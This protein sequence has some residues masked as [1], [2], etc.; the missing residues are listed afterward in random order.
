MVAAASVVASYCLLAAPFVAR[1]RLPWVAAAVL[2]L[3]LCAA[4][5]RAWQL[6][7]GGEAVAELLGARLLDGERATPPERRLLNVVHEMSIA[8]S[9]P[10]PPVYILEERAVNALVAGV[11]P[12]HAVIVVTRG[13]VETLSRDELQAVMGHEYS[14]IVNGDMALNLRMVALLAGLSWLGDRGEELVWR[15]ARGLRDSRSDRTPLGFSA[16]AGAIVAF[17]GFPGVVAADAIRAAVARQR[18]LLADQASVQFTRNAEGV[19]GALDTILA[20][21]AGTSVRAAHAAE[22]SHLFFASAVAHW[23]SFATHPPIEQR[24]YRADPRFDRDG[25]RARRHGRRREVAIID[26]GGNVVRHVP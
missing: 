23:W 5:Y 2:A 1:D 11:D 10:A 6:R 14:H 22:L 24:I 15:S 3:V 18:E 16:L 21:R 8:A 20:T 17:A 13:A 25:Y 12:G 4:A 19:A 7:D 9:I 26:G